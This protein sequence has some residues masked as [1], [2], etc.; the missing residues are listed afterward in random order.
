VPGEA[1]FYIPAIGSTARPRVTLKHDDTFA[2]FDSHGD[3]GATVGSPDG[4]FAG[5][6]RLL[7]HLELQ[8]NGTEP[9]LLGSA[10]R[11]D[12]LNFYVDLTNPDIYKNDKIILLK[13]TVHI[14]RTIYLIDGSLRERIALTNYGGQEVEFTLSL[15][16][17]SDFADIF[18]VRGVRR[19]RRGQAWHLVKGASRVIL[20]YRGL[21]RALRETTLSFEPPPSSL[22]ERVATYSVRLAQGERRTIFV[23][24]SNGG[25]QFGSTASFFKGLAG[26]HRQRRSVTRAAAAV[27]TSNDVLNEIL[28]R[29]MADLHMLVTSTADGPYPYAGI[30]WYST[31][32]GR[33][34][35]ISAMQML[36]ADPAIAKGPSVSTTGA[37]TQRHCLWCS[38]A[39]MRSA[40][41]T[42]RWCARYGRRLNG[43]SL[44]LIAGVTSM[45][46]G[47][48]N[49]RERPRRALPTRAGKIR[50]MPYSMRTADW[51]KARSRSPRCRAMCTWPNVWPQLVRTNWA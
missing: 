8:I 21:D 38:L 31:T 22:T 47:S 35:I 46:T 29:S 10:I 5:D 7:S 23:T 50:T 36:W 33:D 49:M 34:G 42:M 9:L 25:W 16:F 1:P 13:D 11:D 20:S 30:P 48:S 43:R 27:E 45:A 24:V 37:S 4:V 17:S 41:A 44:G 19:K 18:E 6:T 28:C 39:S 51:R 15:T 14:A 3:I 2:V 32:F 12:N 40:L 26:L